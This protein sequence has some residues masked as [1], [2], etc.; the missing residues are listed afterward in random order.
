MH[1]QPKFN[2][3]NTTYDIMSKSDRI[4]AALAGL[5]SQV[6]SNYPTTAKKHGV[7]RA[8]LLGRFTGKTDLKYEATTE[9]RQALNIAQEEVLLG[10]IQRLV[11]RGIPSTPTFVR[12]FAE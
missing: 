11:T 2:L 5:E 9:H 4:A 1:T 12:N 10:H 7:V 6:V 3:P 8:P